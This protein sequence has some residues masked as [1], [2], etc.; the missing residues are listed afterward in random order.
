MSFVTGGIIC[1]NSAALS[2]EAILDIFKRDNY[3]SSDKISMESATSVEFMGTGIARIDNMVIVFD[4]SLAQSLSFTKTP[5]SAINE[6]LEMLSRKGD[7]L[8]FSMNGYSDTY[9]W[10]IYSKG[11]KIRF[12]SI[13]DGEIL[14]D[15]GSPTSY[16]QELAIN[17]SALIKLIENFTGYSYIT[18]VFE[19][20]IGVKAYYK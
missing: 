1:K 6:T 16:D 13:T 4:I 10:S 20:H 2:D 19:K 18:L 8:C 9:A 11:K 14:S 17:E 15:F 12:K 7:I 3:T 5:P